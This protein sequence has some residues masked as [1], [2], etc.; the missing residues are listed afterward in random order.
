MNMKHFSKLPWLVL[1]IFLLGASRASAAGPADQCVVTVKKVEL[2]NTAGDWFVL[3]DSD[4]KLD[5]AAK[6]PGLDLVNNGRLPAGDYVSCKLTLSETVVVSGVDGKNKT[7]EGGEVTIGGSAGVAADLPG[8][9]TQ[10]D[11][12]SP[13]WNTEK[14]GAIKVN[15][16]LDYRDRDNIM[17]IYLKREFQ[18]PVA[19]KEG[20][21]IRIALRVDLNETVHY[22]WP[23]YFNG[24]PAKE[25]MY[26]LPPDHV[27]EVSLKSDAV[28]TIATSDIEWKF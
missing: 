20:S 24:F 3:S 7:K 25:T 5:L 19:V 2:K 13:T 28:S 1:S 10:L 12:V 15:L 14:E 17:E 23:N 26:F 11:E 6:D 9:I 8:E 16:D 18:K 21:K 22:A 4:A 27:S